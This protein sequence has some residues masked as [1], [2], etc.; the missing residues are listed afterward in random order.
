MEK[1]RMSTYTDTLIA[2]DFPSFV[3]ECHKICRGGKALGKDPYLLLLFALSEDIVTGEVPKAAISMPPGTAKT[4]IFAV[5][6][7]AWMLAH[8]P[9]ATVMVVGH[10]KKLARDITRNILKIMR[11]DAFRRNFK[12]RIDEA[13]RGAG[14][15]GTTKG[16]S[17]YATSVSG[18][19]TGYRADL[20]VVDDPLSIKNANNSDK[21]EFVNETFDDEILSRMR[22]DES[23]VVV[24]MHR[25][26]ANDLISHVTRKG[27]YKK[28]ELP[29]IADK[30]RTYSSR[31]GVWERKTGEQLRRGR[32]TKSELRDL[33]FK[34]IFRFL[35]QQGRAGG[36]S[37]RVKPRHFRYC[38]GGR[39]TSLPVVLSVDTAQKAGPN[40]S[41]MVI[42]VWQTDGRD[43]DLLDVFAAV[44]DYE[45]LWHE[46]T[47]LAKK[48]RPS[49]ILIED[50]A[51]GSALLS[52]AQA[53]LNFEVTGVVPRKSKSQRF[54]RHYKTIQNGHVRLPTEAD[55]VTDWIQEI[56]AFPDSEHDDHVDALS[57]LLDFMATKPRL[58]VPRQET[59]RGVLVR[60]NDAALEVHNRQGL[61]VRGM[62]I[63]TASG[64]F[65]SISRNSV[66]SS[67]GAGPTAF[68]GTPEGIVSLKF[69]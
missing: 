1:N 50:T 34:P 10:S 59:L 22:D 46:L 57:M 25:L 44:C 28:L 4:F 27:G 3:R 9:S 66:E 19:I 43:H 6:L 29:L 69:R 54:R 58:T 24:V 60:R 32:Y 42:Q 39:D 8:N 56:S 47:K 35:F 21:I 38:D 64:I 26:N 5:C 31:Y 61:S 23:R 49:M 55:W 20:I 12:T 18:T 40:S 67:S 65:E 33:A 16:G 68:C 15:F 11:S 14:D 45:R 13:W 51:A 41:R 2:R 30:D 63:A 7:T 37:L 17:V 62:E 48:Y 36:A 53:R 52:Q